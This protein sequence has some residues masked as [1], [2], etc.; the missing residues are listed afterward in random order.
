MK[1][2]FS[3]LIVSLLVANSALADDGLATIKSMHNVQKTADRFERMIKNAGLNLYLRVNH[4]SDAK[5]VGLS[6]KPSQVIVFGSPKVGTHLM[7]CSE[8]VAIDLP[9][10][11]LI[12]EDAQGRVWLSYNR[13]KFLVKRHSIKGCDKVVEKMDGLLAKFAWSS[14]GED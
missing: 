6:L 10:K 2:F 1:K 13:P 3:A 7:N 12:R 5:K 14:T 11:V 8:S 4:S 9:L